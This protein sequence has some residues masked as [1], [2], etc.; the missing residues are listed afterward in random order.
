VKR[1]PAKGLALAVVVCGAAACTD[2][3][4]VLLHIHDATPADQM[5]V[6]AATAFGTVTHLVAAPSGQVSFIATFRP[7]IGTVSFAVQPL[8]AGKPAGSCAS[9]AIAVPPHQVVSAD[10]ACGRSPATDGGAP[11]DLAGS[12]DGAIAPDYFT[13]VQ[14]DKPLAYYHLG[15]TAAAGTTAADSSGNRQDG[16]YGASVARHQP[17]P[18]VNARAVMDGAA[19]FP[20]GTATAAQTVRAVGN[21]LL[22]PK[23]A[24]SIELWLSSAGANAG[25]V[26]LQY[27]F[28]SAK[29]VPV[30]ALS[31]QQDHVVF[32]VHAAAGNAAGTLTSNA[33]IT[34]NTPY[35]VVGT[36]DE[37]TMTMGLWING[38]LDISATGNSGDIIHGDPTTSGIGIGGGHNDGA[39]AWNGIIDEVAIY[40]YALAPARVQAHYASGS[41][42]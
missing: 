16:T 1:L 14:D 9:R 23:T 41:Q 35:H 7:E 20:G 17:S 29:V 6:T 4:G 5:S 10:I 30:Y 26:L 2:T 37:A 34:A 24:I 40:G 21:G 15:E 33:V 13:T 28:F 11:G 27:D 19:G 18:L 22:L 36:Y 8:A 32:L 25:A 12:G 31:L 3:T 38:K 39:V 42:P